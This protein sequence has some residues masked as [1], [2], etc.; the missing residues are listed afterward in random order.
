MILIWDLVIPDLPRVLD[1]RP[2]L[3]RRSDARRDPCTRRPT[4]LRGPTDM[5]RHPPCT[6][7]TPPA[8]GH[9]Q[10]TS[11]TEPAAFP[12]N[13]RSPLKTTGP[14]MSS[15]KSAS[16]R[17][18]AAGGA[19]PVLIVGPCSADPNAR[20]FAPTTEWPAR[21]QPPTDDPLAPYANIGPVH[22]A[23]GR[24]SAAGGAI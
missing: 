20:S 5:Y 23:S 8:G 1:R 22:T 9:P 13:W 24:L 18:R 19:A 3:V 21:K 2:E 6:Q 16:G 7:L 11:L 14:P 4:A 15:W 10:E 17:L 12:S